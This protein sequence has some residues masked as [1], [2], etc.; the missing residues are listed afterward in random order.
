MAYG[1]LFQVSQ[2]NGRGLMGESLTGSCA[3]PVVCIV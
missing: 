2:G 3:P 1:R